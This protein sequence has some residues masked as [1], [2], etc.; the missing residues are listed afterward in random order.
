MNA[1]LLEEVEPMKFI[2]NGRTFDTSTSST[3][4]ISRGTAGPFSPTIQEYPGS[5]SVRY[6]DVLYRTAK[7]AWFVHE[8]RTIKYQ[9]G[10]PVV[11]DG[12]YELKPDDVLGWIDK[13]NASI[14]DPTGL[15]LPEEA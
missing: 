10:K 8:H 3:A 7:G 15:N 1:I 2:L 6:E 4:A 11:E 9:R 14:V 5:E 12:S 13:N